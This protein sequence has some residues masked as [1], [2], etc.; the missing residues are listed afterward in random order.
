VAAIYRRLLPPER[1]LAVNMPGA[2][3]SSTTRSLAGELADNLGCLYAEVPIGR[4]VEVT[5][6]QLD[7]LEIADRRGGR[8]QRLRLTGFALENVQARDR[9]SRILAALASAFGGVFTCNA[10][11]SEAAVGYTTLYGDLAGYLANIADLWKGEVYALADHL[12]RE[13]FGGE[14]IPRG[15]LELPPSAE[16]G[17]GQNVDEGKGDPLHYPYHDALF[18]SWVEQWDRAAPVDILRWHREGRL[19]A[20]LGIEE[21]PVELFSSPAAFVEDLER[22]WSRFQGLGLAKRIQAPPVLGVKRRAFGFDYREAQLGVFF[23]RA[24]RRLKEELLGG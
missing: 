4:S 19:A 11:K 9:S 6:A 20:E 1:L 21:E 17:P 16:L 23:G 2:Y 18:A 15:T 22:W 3:S 14:V 5:C 24:Y 12:N 7:G 8:K 10:N 13:V